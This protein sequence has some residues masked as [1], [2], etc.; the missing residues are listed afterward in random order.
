MNKSLLKAEMSRYE[1]TQATLAKALG[2]SLSRLNAK[3]NETGGAEFTQTEILFIKER[4]R[5]DPSA[6][7]SIFF[8]E[9]VS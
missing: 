2:I 3:I 7:D 1:D 5:L 8:A 6:I 9:K 4:Y